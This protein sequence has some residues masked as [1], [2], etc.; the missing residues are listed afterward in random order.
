MVVW[1]HL[2]SFI[3]NKIWSLGTF[4][5]NYSVL[6]ALLYIFSRII[7]VILQ[8]GDIISFFTK[9]GKLKFTSVNNLSQVIE[10]ISNRPK[11]PI[12]ICLTAKAIYFS[13]FCSELVKL[14]C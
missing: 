9:G 11:T 13:L 2:H 4:K 7:T 5:L 12:P 14:L 8:V 3:P 1:I 10:L 6:G